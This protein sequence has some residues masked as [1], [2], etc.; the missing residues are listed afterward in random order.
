[1][2]CSQGKPKRRQK[3]FDSL[4]NGKSKSVYIT[5][6]IYLSVSFYGRTLLF[7]QNFNDVSGFRFI[8]YNEEVHIMLGKKNKSWHRVIYDQY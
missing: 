6:M 2:P 5:W 3:T 8:S 7:A 1:M 4:G